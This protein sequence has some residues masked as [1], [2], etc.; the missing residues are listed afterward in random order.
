M[1]GNKTYTIVAKSPNPSVIPS[2]C[3]MKI[4]A[5]ATNN[6][7]PSLFTVAPIGST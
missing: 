5:T 2:I 1:N 3:A 6:A 4:D 7:V